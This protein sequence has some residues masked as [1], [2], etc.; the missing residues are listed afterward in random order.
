MRLFFTTLLLAFSLYLAAQPTI[1]KDAQTLITGTWASG[2]TG[3]SATLTEVT[4][5]TPHEGTKHYK[6]VYSFAEW[7][8]GVG[9]NMDNWGGAAARNLSGYSHLRIA[10]RGLSAGQNLKIQLRNGTTYGNLI[11]IGGN[12]SAYAVV[13]ITMFSL[14][15]GTT[16]N[17]NA[18]REID[19]SVNSNT[20]AGSGTV[21]FD[22]IEMVN[23]ATPPAPASAATQAR[24]AALGTGVNATNWLEAY[25]LIPF[26]AYPEFNKYNRTKIRD[27]HLAGF[28]TFRLPVT[29]ERL[30]ST[31]PPYALNFG[32]VA[33]D[34]VD[35]MILWANIYDFKLIIDNHHGY[36]LTNA[37]YAAN[38]PRLKAVWQQLT[39]RYDYLNPEQFFFEISNEPTNE[40]SNAN[41]K[42][43]ADSLI[44][45]VRLNESQTHSV[46][47]GAAEWNSGNALL[48]FTPLSDPDIIY[49]FHNY[50]PYFFTH[51]GM[52]WTSPP[53][54][55]PRT[56]PQA[57]EVAAINALFTSLKTWGTNY[58][59]PVNLGE[60]GCA[61]AADATSRC[62]WIN[63]LANA[64][65][66]N[67]FSNFYW[68]AI[69]PSDAFGFYTGGVISEA[70]C[71]P[72]FK[73]ALGLY[74]VPLPVSL[75]A[76]TVTCEQDKVL[77]KWSAFVAGKG[78][79]F[80]IENSSNGG[81][82]WSTV[83]TQQ[84]QE[85][86][87]NYQIVDY[88]TTQKLYRVKTTDENGAVDYSPAQSIYCGK[89]G[90]VRIFPNPSH[91]QTTVQIEGDS[92][93]LTDIAMYDIAGRLIFSKAFEAD[94]QVRF[95]MIPTSQ[96]PAGTY[97][98]RVTTDSG[99][100][101]VQQVVVDR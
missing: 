42:V 36:T 30:G 5:E 9:L 57:G 27:L 96:Y 94:Q 23:T 54:F 39:D 85:G 70:T 17:A 101:E 64:I 87:N 40:I 43:V 77:V 22:A 75:D 33:F 26:N 20:P 84:A 80:E 16:L 95:T 24:A 83:K 58:S 25:W 15:T 81:I 11:E 65:N 48:S 82:D 18:V 86:D 59:V 99:M 90:V 41:W 56:F 1:Y 31:S 98:V 73:T 88:S 3:G 71:I 53:N 63:T 28:S 38:I 61:T 10:Y 62:N 67:G 51:Q 2:G 29:F 6:L 74:P 60:F 52:S 46:L 8:A 12:N 68:D 44:A 4:G 7:W 89:Q 69:T 72:C 79:V 66:T 34:L 78:I 55:P 37:N 21:Y 45:V 97:M 50:D 14:T 100:V 32:H 35:S 92:A 47:V 13:D 19:I 76:F 93:L 91:D 49:T